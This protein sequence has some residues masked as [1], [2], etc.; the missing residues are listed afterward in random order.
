MPADPKP[1][2]T[3]YLLVQ[4]TVTSPSRPREPDEYVLEHKSTLRLVNDETDEDGHA[5][6]K[7]KWARV[8]L[9]AAINGG[10]PAF[11]VFDAK[12]QDLCSMYESL[13]DPATDELK[14]PFDDDITEDLLYFEEFELLDPAI[15][16]QEAAEELIEHVLHLF[17]GRALA[18]FFRGGTD[19]LRFVAALRARGFVTV[20][21]DHGAPLYAV[22]L[23]RKRPPPRD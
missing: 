8:A 21:G 14:P 23:T 17:G 2:S 3:Q 9:G 11:D 16:E 20:R 22:P 1:L 6:A 7:L 15:D 10:V 5:I 19:T 12:S 18:T 13:F 4:T